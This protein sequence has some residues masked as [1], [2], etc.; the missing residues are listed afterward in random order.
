MNRIAFTMTLLPGN[1]EEYK[2]RHDEIW[3]ELADLLRGSGI[4]DYSIHLDARTSTLFALL[5]R[6]DDHHMDSLADHPVMKR[7]W[8]YMSDI[9]VTHEDLSPVTSE[10]TPVFY[11]K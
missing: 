3:P 8:E 2:R 5:T 1:E 7:W 6:A 4:S 11:M 9:M 10:L